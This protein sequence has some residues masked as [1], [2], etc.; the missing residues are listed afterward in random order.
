MSEPGRYQRAVNAG[1]EPD[2]GLPITTDERLNLGCGRDQPKRWTNVDCVETV[3]PDRVVDL[4]D[5]PWPWT[6]GSVREVHAEHVLEHLDNAVGALREIERVLVPGGKATLVWPIGHTRGEDPTHEQRWSVATAEW[7]GGSDTKHGHELDTDLTLVERDVDWSLSQ[8]D[9][10][11]RLVEIA[12]AAWGVGPWMEQVPGVYG[13][14]RAR[15]RL[16][17]SDA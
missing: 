11:E 7:I 13:E 8:S 10:G 3:H 1:D 4:D 15:Y 2:I 17:V 6:D 12:T 9:V 14:V 16:E 5:Q